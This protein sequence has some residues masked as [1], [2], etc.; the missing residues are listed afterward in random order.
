MD[1]DNRILNKKT[2]REQFNSFDENKENSQKI[3]G[4][5][6]EANVLL[7]SCLNVNDESNEMKKGKTSDIKTIKYEVEETRPSTF[8]SVEMKENNE[9]S[10]MQIEGKKNSK[11]VKN[12]LNSKKN[13]KIKNRNIKDVSDIFTKY[14]KKRYK[15]K[16][17]YS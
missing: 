13:R 2:K 3:E 8:F 1:N 6:K 17:Y 12:S 5:Q 7:F 4:Y 10:I 15:I 11:E 14:K 16:K 9:N